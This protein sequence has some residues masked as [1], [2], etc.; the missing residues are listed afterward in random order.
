M[1]CMNKTPQEDLALPPAVM[2]AGPTASGKSALALALAETFNGVVI[3][4]DSMQ[5]YETLHLLTARPSAAEEQRAPHRVYGVISPACVCSATMWKA[6]AV[7]A[8]TEAWDQGKLPIV[9][10]GT[11]FYLQTLKD[12]ISPIPD[13]P[14]AIREDARNRL[15][16]LGN[17]AFHAELAQHDPVMA[18]RL[19]V[20]N[21]QRL[22]RAWEV[23]E[24]TQRSLADWQ[25]AP[26][27]GAVPARWYSLVLAPPREDLHQACVARFA[28]MI[29]DGAPEEVR[30]LLALG[31]DP[32]L[33]A[34]KALGVPEL[35]AALRGE[36]SLETASTLACQ[37]TRRY[38]K[39]Q[40][41]WF[42]H[43][44]RASKTIHAQFYNSLATEIF[45]FI[46]EF[47]LTPESGAA[48]L[49]T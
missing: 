14:P 34:M 40:E 18:A 26:R 24:A 28:R 35:A 41:T 10:G 4:A 11:G 38:A 6:L 22:A 12:G 13:I 21:S 48:S 31:L 27:Q 49:T 45:P 15:A 43:H 44:I 30:Q 36:I 9:T 8:M 16:T 47:L 33:P 3:N 29:A 25:A 2:V 46:R 20:G 17:A 39:R 19:D 5:V 1:R 32:A 42:R 7:E 23:L 37:A